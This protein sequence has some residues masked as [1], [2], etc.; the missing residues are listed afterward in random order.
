MASASS[1]APIPRPDEWET[2]YVPA[3]LRNLGNTCFF[4]SVVQCLSASPDFANQ[5]HFRMEDELAPGSLGLEF[6]RSVSKM[7]TKNSNVSPQNLLNEVVSRFP[8]YRGKR[9]QDAHEF[10]RL[11]LHGVTDEPAEGFDRKPSALSSDIEKF[12]KGHLCN[13]TRCKKCSSVSYVLEDILDISLEMPTK[14]AS[15]SNSANAEPRKSKS[16]LKADK[17]ENKANV[18]FE[19]LEDSLVAEDFGT[20]MAELEELMKQ[21]NPKQRKMLTKRKGRLIKSRRK[22]AKDDIK[23]DLGKAGAGK[24]KKLKADKSLFDEPPTFPANMS[25]KAIQDELK[26]IFA[27]DEWPP[28]A[29]VIFND[30]IS[31]LAKS[32][33]TGFRRQWDTKVKEIG[34]PEKEP[35]KKVTLVDDCGSKDGQCE[36]DGDNDDNVDG[37]DENDGEDEDENEEGEETV[38][39]GYPGA[40]MDGLPYRKESDAMTPD[41]MEA[42]AFSGALFFV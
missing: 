11:L 41:E 25:Q 13:V 29:Q 24:K 8:F 5:L 15:G 4:N 26:D 33:Q 2:P 28:H 9:Q 40:K 18:I 20:K 27:S 12:F 14:S 6:C 31:R 3:G 22:A 7:H 17:P 39:Q 10:L 34:Q 16:K 30:L 21:I 36:N 23:E 37:D 19:Y 42:Q 35:K 1:R 38:G 32:K